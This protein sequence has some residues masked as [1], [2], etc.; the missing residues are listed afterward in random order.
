MWYKIPISNLSK[1]SHFSNSKCH[2]IRG[3]KINDFPEGNANLL[4]ETAISIDYYKLSKIILEIM[5]LKNAY[6]SDHLST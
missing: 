5:N 4:H 3:F 2:L 1:I 6:F